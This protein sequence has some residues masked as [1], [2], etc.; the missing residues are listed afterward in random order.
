MN[1][2]V[3]IINKQKKCDVKEDENKFN[4]NFLNNYN[5]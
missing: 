2:V 4:F 5:C 1:K 3:D